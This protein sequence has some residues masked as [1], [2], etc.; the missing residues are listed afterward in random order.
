MCFLTYRSRDAAN[1]CVFIACWAQGTEAEQAA[2]ISFAGKAA[3]LAGTKILTGH[4]S[5]GG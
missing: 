2:G 5:G 4:V 3:D 1:L